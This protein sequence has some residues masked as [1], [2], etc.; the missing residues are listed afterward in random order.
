MDYKEYQIKI[1]ESI[2]KYEQA[3]GGWWKYLGNPRKLYAQARDLI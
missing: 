2:V 3:T 1:V